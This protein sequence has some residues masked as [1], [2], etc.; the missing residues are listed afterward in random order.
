MTIAT[1]NGIH[2]VRSWASHTTGLALLS[3]VGGILLHGFAAAGPIPLITQTPASPGIGEQIMYTVVY[4]N[5]QDA[6]LDALTI[7]D[8]VSPVIM[9][10]SVSQPVGWTAPTVT[11]VAGVG[12]RYVWSNSFVSLPLGESLTFTIT[13]SV[14]LVC[15]PTLVGTTAQVDA[16]WGGGVSTSRMITNEVGY[17]VQPHLTG[18]SVLKQQI[19]VSPGAGGA[20]NYTIVVTNTGTATLDSLTVT[21]TISQVITGAVPSQPSGWSAPAVTNMPGIGTQYVWSRTGINMIPGTSLTFQVDGVVGKV[22][23]PTL[24]SNTAYAA[25]QSACAAVGAYSNETDFTLLPSATLDVTATMQQSPAS[26]ATG[27]TVTYIIMAV[28]SGN[29]IIKEMTVTDTISPV[30]TGQGMAEPSGFGPPTIVSISGTGSLYVWNSTSLSLKPGQSLPFAITGA[31][32]AVNVNTLVNNIAQVTAGNGIGKAVALTKQ[33]SFTVSPVPPDLRVTQTLSTPSPVSGG[34]VKYLVTVVNTGTKPI[35]NLTVI[36]T[37]SPV[38]MNVGTVEPSGFGK[39]TIVSIAGTGSRFVWTATGL[40]LLPGQ[41]LT[42][43]ITGTVGTVD[44]ATTVSNHAGAGSTY[45]G[46]ALWS[47]TP[48]VSFNLAPTGPSLDPGKVKIVGGIRGY[49]NPKLGEQ[50]TILLRPSG[51]GEI[52]MRVFNLKGEIV[53]VIRDTA[54]GGN[55]VLVLHWNATDESGAQVPPGAYPVIIE[56]PGVRYRDT[57]AVLR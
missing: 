36:D 35:T 50:A 1:T 54:T 23:V 15:A 4:T 52:I 39:P 18:I 46:G 33:T 5:A 30:V 29:T 37:L 53:R 12:T 6:S 27:E 40:N 22:A 17:V 16:T 28:N 3:A 8:T 45:P 31:V 49:I 48:A 7:T 51:A 56:G 43:T 34:T 38:I 2:A 11:S 14:G 41:S 21:D 47:S 10:V 20:V 26:P 55:H 44:E 13:G 25:A 9:D 24:V 42:I 32:G 57:L 19:P